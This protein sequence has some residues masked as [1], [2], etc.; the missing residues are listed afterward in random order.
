MSGP[1][2]P[3]PCLTRD[4]DHFS[5]EFESG[6]T[7]RDYFAAQALPSVF[8][9]AAS[10]T[11]GKRDKPEVAEWTAGIATVAYALADAMLA[12]REGGEK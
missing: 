11:D 12:A 7:L 2:F 1:A 9:R 6:M 4:G 8:A 10:I 5:T 3:T